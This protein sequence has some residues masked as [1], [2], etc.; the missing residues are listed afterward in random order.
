MEKAFEYIVLEYPFSFWQYHHIECEFI[1]DENASPDEMLEHLDRVVSFS[2]YS[3]RAMNS[4]SMYQFLTELGYYGYVT[5]NVDDLLSSTDYSNTVFAPQNTDLVY[6]AEVM[7]DI[8]RWLKDFGNNIL[9]IY[10]ENDPWSAPSVAL[11]SRVNAEKRI[12]SS[13]NHYTFIRNFPD[14]ER[15]DI[16][17][18]LGNWLSMNITD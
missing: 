5:K 4:P 2:S 12:L 13:G 18:I 6:N 17:S 7:Q 9:Y 10:A 16:C 14:T 8:E 1:P 11:S 3:D 15:E